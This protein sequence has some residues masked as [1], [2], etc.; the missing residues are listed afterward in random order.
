MDKEFINLSDSFETL[1]RYLYGGHNFR[2]DSGLKTCA[3]WKHRMI[4]IIDSIE[5]S[6]D[7]TI[8][9]SDRKHKAQLLS[10]CKNTKEEISKVS[11]LNGL[12][13]KTILGLIKLIFYLLGDRPDHFD[14]QKVN[15]SDHWRLNSHRQIMYYQNN[16]Q[17][18]RL[19]IDQAPQID[20]WNDGVYNRNILIAKLHRELSGDHAKFLDWYKDEYPDKYYEFY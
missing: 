11:N 20:E 6:I 9:I 15:K 14:L 10:I 3:E 8:E 7:K 13:E 12:N 2:Y 1:L 19:I 4:K 5:F 18:V 17:K 16:E